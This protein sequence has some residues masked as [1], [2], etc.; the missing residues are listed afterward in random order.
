MGGSYDS[1][2][3]FVRTMPLL[4]KPSF[5]FEWRYLNPCRVF[6]L[7]TGG[8]EGRG[9]GRASSIQAGGV[10]V[11]SSFAAGLFSLQFLALFSL[12]SLFGWIQNLPM[13]SRAESGWT[14]E[15]A[16]CEVD[17]G[18]VW[19]EAVFK[20]DYCSPQ[21]RPSKYRRPFASK[22]IY[23]MF[24]PNCDARPTSKEFTMLEIKFTVVVCGGWAGSSC[25]SRSS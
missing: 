17:L 25:L 21:P 12:V 6:L 1:E 11:M 19:C 23:L 5:A 16:W 2:L 15:D 8:W 7:F 14:F 22:R 20:V 3:L 18:Q 24:F 10:T 13:P 4:V 9:G